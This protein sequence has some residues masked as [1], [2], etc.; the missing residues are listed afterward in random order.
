[1]LNFRWG[2]PNIFPLSPKGEQFVN[3]I[4]KKASE[5]LL[6]ALS[7]F[8]IPTICSSLTALLS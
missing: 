5:D 7:S 3:W 4:D 2:I 1:M 6:P 8:R